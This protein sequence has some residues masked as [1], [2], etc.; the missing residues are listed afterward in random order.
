MKNLLLI[1]LAVASLPAY[2]YIGPGMGAGAIAAALGLLGAIFLAIFGVL[3][4]PIKR[5][6]KKRKSDKQTNDNS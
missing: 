6:L 1:G 3:Y 2:A 4:Y 5:F